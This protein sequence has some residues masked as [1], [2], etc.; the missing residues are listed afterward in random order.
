MRAVVDIGSNSIKYTLELSLGTASSR[1]GDSRVIALGKNLKKG[2]PLSAEALSRLDA[3]LAEFAKPIRTTAGS[4]IV[5][6][7]TAALRNCS[8][9]DAAAALVQKHLGVPLHVITGEREA[10][11]SFLGAIGD[12]PFQ[13]PLCVDVGGASTEV[14]L[15]KAGLA[16]SVP[17][18]ALRVHETI[19]KSQCPVE[20]G[21]WASAQPEL[22][23]IFAQELRSA[24]G[25]LNGQQPDGVL[26]IG[27]SLMMTAKSLH[28]ETQ[29]QRTVRTKLSALQRFNNQI[30]P[31]ST[32][33]R[34][35]VLGFS[36][37]RAEIGC[38]GL[39]CLFAATAWLPGLDDA[40][41]TEGGLR[42]GVFLAWDEFF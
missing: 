27:G 4:Q 37:D 9:P 33:T 5:V 36:A 14:G 22:N 30:A 18:G 26:A 31:L 17:W 23:A 35:A 39:M 24:L 3:A 12:S 34:V 38:A 21:L 16:H 11:L 20:P 32:E 29:K 41:I 25:N 7:G 1:S 2:A 40:L 28:P 15:A 6:V 10:Q 42:S 13:N 8:N 19:L